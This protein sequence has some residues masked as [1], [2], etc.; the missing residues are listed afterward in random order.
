MNISKNKDLIASEIRKGLE[1][2][3]AL[4]AFGN[5]DNAVTCGVEF[6]EAEKYHIVVKGSGHFYI[7]Q[8]P[9]NQRFLL[10]AFLKSEHDIQF[11][12]D[13]IRLVFQVE[14]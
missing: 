1:E 7:N 13:T 12:A 6:S 9:D 2:T 14:D 10:K 11:I 3:D 8:R 5:D 4:Y